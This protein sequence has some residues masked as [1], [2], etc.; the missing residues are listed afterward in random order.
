MLHHWAVNNTIPKWSVNLER[1]P[2]TYLPTEQLQREY[3]EYVIRQDRPSYFGVPTTSDY[4]HET[5]DNSLI[6][7]STL[8]WTMIPH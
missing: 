4:I 8:L 1:D 2:S 5:E 6:C 3:A 7:L